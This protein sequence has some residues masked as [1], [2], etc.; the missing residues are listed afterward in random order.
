[1]G[2]YLQ[3]RV[4]ATTYKPAELESAWPKLHEFAWPNQKGAY[5]PA[6]EVHGVMEMAQ[7]L[8]DQS[9]F[10]EWDDYTKK[11]LASGIEEAL[12]VT[13]QLEKAL[14]EWDPRRA[15][16]LSDHLEDL[17]SELEKAAATC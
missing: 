4:S 15:N 8:D 17:F 16:S 5:A 7:A 3:I 6:H 13:A 2:K 11:T 1:M 12:K 14:E 10:G 9:R